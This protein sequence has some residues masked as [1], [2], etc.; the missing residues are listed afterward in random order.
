MVNDLF[1]VCQVVNSRRHARYICH[2]IF[3]VLGDR[4]EEVNF[5]GAIVKKSC[6]GGNREFRV[7]EECVISFSRM[8]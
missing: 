8:G 4:K 6:V 3:Y 5:L 7:N 2:I 1:A